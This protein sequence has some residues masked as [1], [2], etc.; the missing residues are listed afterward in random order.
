MENDIAEESKWKQPP[1]VFTP[2]K[3]YQPTR[4][5]SPLNIKTDFDLDQPFAQ[6]PMTSRNT[7]KAFTKLKGFKT[8]TTQRSSE[9]IKKAVKITNTHLNNNEKLIEA[10]KEGNSIAVEQ[11]LT[12]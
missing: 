2:I 8:L 1:K 4:N 3:K 9:I 6:L 5:S 7:N 11:L 12:L 10:V